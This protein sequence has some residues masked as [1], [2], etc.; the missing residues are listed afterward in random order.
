MRSYN[1][2]MT[3]QTFKTSLIV[4]FIVVAMAYIALLIDRFLIHPVWF[5]L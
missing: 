5:N 2:A 1:A 3:R 4:L